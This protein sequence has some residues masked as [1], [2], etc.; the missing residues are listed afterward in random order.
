MNELRTSP[1]SSTIVASASKDF[2]VR[3]WNINRSE[4]L[5]IL[6]GVHGH[7]DQVLS[8]VRAKKI[9]PTLIDMQYQDF[10]STARYVVTAGMDHEVKLYD[11]SALTYSDSHKERKQ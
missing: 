6:G 5:V 3:L 8:L 11:I 4:C 1:A 2:T 9:Q 7:R 10:D